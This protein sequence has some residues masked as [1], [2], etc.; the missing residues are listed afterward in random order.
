MAEEANAFSVGNN[1][2]CSDK[3]G[4]KNECNDSKGANARVRTE[5]E[6]SS[7]MGLLYNGGG[8][9]KEL[10]CLW[11]IWAYGPTLQKQ[12]KRKGNRGKES[13]IWRRKNQGD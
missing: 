10:L 2:A 1:R 9:G 3:G 5:Y 12:G 11:R 7:Q 6:G 8:S 13:S 4:K